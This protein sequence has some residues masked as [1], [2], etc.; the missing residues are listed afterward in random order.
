MLVHR[1]DYDIILSWDRVGRFRWNFFYL[2]ARQIDVWSDWKIFNVRVVH[3]VSSRTQSSISLNYRVIALFLSIPP[4]L[5]YDL[6]FVLHNRLNLSTSSISLNLNLP[7]SLEQKQNLFSF[8]LVVIPRK[9][10]EVK[11]IIR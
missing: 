10:G 8:S 1:I 2:F 6:H 7:K 9:K 3:S 5:S 4:V 11:I